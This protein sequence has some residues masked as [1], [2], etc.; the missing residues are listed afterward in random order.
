[1]LQKHPSGA[2]R[3]AIRADSPL[4]ATAGWLPPV[5]ATLSLVSPPDLPFEV[6][7]AIMASCGALMGLVYGRSLPR[8]ALSWSVLALSAA[9]SA[10]FM[11]SATDLSRA[12]VVL[13]TTL[14]TFRLV[15]LMQEEVIPGPLDR[16]IYVLA[17][18]ETTLAREIEPWL[19]V[20]GAAACLAWMVCGSTALSLLLLAPQPEG[21]L[22]AVMRW[23]LTLIAFYCLIELMVGTLRTGLRA[24]GVEIL[25]AHDHPAMATS[26]HDFWS[27]RWNLLV[28]RWLHRNV[29][30]RV[31][32]RHGVVQGVAAAFAVSTALH[33][34]IMAAT[35]GFW[36][37][38]MWALFFMLQGA[39]LVIER[40]LAI[41]RRPAPVP[42]LWTLTVML[43]SSAL[44]VYPVSQVLLDPRVVEGFRS[45]VFAI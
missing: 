6:A 27:K 38:V 16:A 12:V 26:V 5:G 34:W 13:G 24:R 21:W 17:P 39:L 3:L 4:E 7:L 35:A 33:L 2:G 22:G 42:R 23:G 30:R 8:R 15:D 43:G 19:D 32:R 14:H 36:P 20:K 29:F 10:F 18:Y 41:R 37:S 40:K 11:T 31:A 1:M 28:H 9:V 44:F 25:P 45:L